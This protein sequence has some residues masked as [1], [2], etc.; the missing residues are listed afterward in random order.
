MIM[1]YQLNVHM[2]CFRV[3]YNIAY[4]LLDNSIQNRLHSLIQSLLQPN[5][6]KVNLHLVCVKLINEFPHCLGKTVSGAVDRTEDCLGIKHR[7]QFRS[8][9]WRNDFR[10]EPV[11]TQPASAAV[12]LMFGHSRLRALEL[13]CDAALDP[14]VDM[15]CLHRDGRYEAHSHD[16]MVAF[17]R[18][19]DGFERV[20]VDDVV[21]HVHGRLQSA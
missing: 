13:L 9:F 18:H 7:V 3:P 6:I 16:G 1:S 21:A 12:Q 5:Y 11:R 14:I 15:V 19:G 4:I 2:I 10:F 8:A 20:A 17:R